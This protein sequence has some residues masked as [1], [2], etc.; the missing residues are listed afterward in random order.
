L[1][2]ETFFKKLEDSPDIKG[3]LD[4]A[5]FIIL[6]S[7]Q[8]YT[9]T[10]CS[11]LNRLTL[12]LQTLPEAKLTLMVDWMKDI[13]SEKFHLMVNG[14]HKLLGVEILKLVPGEQLDK[15]DTKAVTE[16]VMAACKLMKMFYKR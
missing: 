14:V 12:L 5:F 6:L 9:V 1:T 7:P 2:Q 8:I 3:K 10:N 4:R 13:D 15:I 16:S 11:M